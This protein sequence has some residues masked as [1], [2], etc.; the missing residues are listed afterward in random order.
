ML[1]S[2]SRALGMCSQMVVNRA[3]GSPIERP[4]S[5]TTERFRQKVGATAELAS[6]R[7]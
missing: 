4:K 2:V 6:G 5:L 1:F 7:G 3:V